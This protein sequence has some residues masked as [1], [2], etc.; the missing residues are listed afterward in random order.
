MTRM[1]CLT[2]SVLSQSSA[3]G[4][5]SSGCPLDIL[6]FIWRVNKLFPKD[7]ILNILDFCVTRSLL[8]LFNSAIAEWSLAK[9]YQYCKEKA[10]GILSC[11]VVTYSG[12]QFYK[13]DSYRWHINKWVWPHSDKIL[14]TKNRSQTVGHVCW[15]QI[16]M[17]FMFQSF[18]SISPQPSF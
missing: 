9:G 1:V 13:I 18:G 3:E 17:N 10:L 4:V 11:E 6:C 15:P 2:T 5:N 14:L 7:Y 8:Q 12:P 16:H